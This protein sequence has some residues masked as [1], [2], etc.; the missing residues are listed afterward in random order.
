MTNEWPE[1]I[2]LVEM[3]LDESSKK[4]KCLIGFNNKKYHLTS[5][6]V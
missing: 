6:Q 3:Y 4:K 1:A 5:Q 2:L